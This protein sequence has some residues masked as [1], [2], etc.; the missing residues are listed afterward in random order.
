MQSTYLDWTG[1]LQE[2]GPHRKGVEERDV[3][4]RKAFQSEM[5]AELARSAAGAV[6]GLADGLA[7]LNLAFGRIQSR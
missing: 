1:L 4:G 7:R 6:W 3:K 5:D 2:P